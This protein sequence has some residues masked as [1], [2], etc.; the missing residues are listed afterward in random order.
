MQ[1]VLAPKA[2]GAWTLH[3][4]TCQDDLDFFLLFSS[5]SAQL[6]LPGQASYVAANTF[7]GAL[8]EHRRAQGLPALAVDLG[9][10]LEAG[11]VARNAELAANLGRMGIEAL[12][13]DDVWEVVD[14][15]LAANAGRATL[16]SI[17]W[18]TLASGA[19]AALA[20]ARAAPTDEPTA[21]ELPGRDRNGSDPRLELLGL[22]PAQRLSVL[23]GHLARSVA[24]VL[25]T[26]ADQLDRDRPLVELGLD[27]LMAVELMAAVQEDVGVRVGLG[28]LLEGM[29]LNDLAE[30]ALRRLAPAMSA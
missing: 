1:S 19:G 11:H 14:A 20:L 27:S 10:M 21:D 28:D 25:E 17:D 29:T 4:L 3:L 8:A 12:A 30:S 13:P 6:A 7:L 26:A 9:A 15:L 23:A 2:G 18:E 22:P 24:R 5:V 16:A